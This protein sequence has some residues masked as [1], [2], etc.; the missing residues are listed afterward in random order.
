MAGS[1]GKHWCFTWNNYDQEDWDRCKNILSNKSFVTYGIMS[2]EVGEL[3]HTRHI[4]G[5]VCFVNRQRMTVLKKKFDSDKIHWEIM[6][7]TPKEASD[8]CK[9]DSVDAEDEDA[10]TPNYVE[11]GELPE[12]ERSRND[13]K[14]MI[15]DFDEGATEAALL[16]AYPSQW[17]MY[18]EKVKRMKQSAV[19]EGKLKDWKGTFQAKDLRRW[20]EAVLRQ[21][22]IQNNRQVLWLVDLEGGKGKTWFG[23]W[24][25]ANKDA[26]VLPNMK[27]DAFDWA[28]AGKDV[29]VFDFARCVGEGINYNNIEKAKN[30]YVYSPKYMGKTAVNANSKV[31]VFSNE[32]PDKT[33][34][35]DDRWF[36]FRLMVPQYVND[37]SRVLVIPEERVCEFE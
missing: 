3:G 33:K 6:R 15:K 21:L 10:N 1:R 37:E 34:L 31:I 29:T 36:I 12:K 30:G 35:S 2:H 7:G 16:S 24:L 25:L 22:E 14:R 23:N 27:S 11:F 32:M 5:Y 4:Q 19:E 13:L 8:Y 17:V 18:G 28:W 9:K 26:Q 20:Q